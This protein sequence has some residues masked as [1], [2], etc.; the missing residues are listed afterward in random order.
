MSLSKSKGDMYNWVTHQHA[1]L[2]GKCP[3]A[4]S[5]CY[6]QAMAKRFP[7]MQA[8]YSGPVQIEAKELKVN[9]GTGKIIF[10]E[11]L[12][13]LFA[14]SVPIETIVQVLDHCFEYPENTYV[15]QTKNPLRY[16]EIAYW[17]SKCVLGTT[18]ESNKKHSCMGD[19]PRPAARMVGMRYMKLLGFKTFITIEPI[20]DFD[21]E[22]LVGIIV[23]AMPD[24]V[25]IG[26]DSKG[27][28]LPE[29]EWSK[30]EELIGAVKGYGVEI[31][32]K[33]NLDRLAKKARTK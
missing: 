9:Y 17:P 28:G 29:P 31:R 3:H 30:V 19:A 26:A 10:I 24:F 16:R 27:N 20:L 32:A 21:V 1:H 7:A 23:E 22:R 18:I 8:K 11:H 13:D 25:N 33:V 14:S 15:F 5:Y 2:S 12:N 6:V 4:C